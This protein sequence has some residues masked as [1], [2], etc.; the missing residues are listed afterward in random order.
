MFEQVGH[1]KRGR[2]V[3]RTRFQHKSVA[4]GNGNGKHPHG[5]HHRKVERRDASYHAQGLAHGPVVNAGRDL[6]GV[7]A[8]EQLRNAGGEFDN[9][10]AAG[11]FA[12]RIG[13]DLAMLSGDH[14]C[15]IVFM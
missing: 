9:F 8:F 12:L 15:E 6:F 11:D 4:A 13:K 7:V 2:W 14:S 1:K 10:N 3:N 5:H